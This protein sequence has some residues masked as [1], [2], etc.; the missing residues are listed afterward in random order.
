MLK[1]LLQD[2]R[3]LA[4]FLIFLGAILFIWGFVL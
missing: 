3:D 2:A 4:A 1:T